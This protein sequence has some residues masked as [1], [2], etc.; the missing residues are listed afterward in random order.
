MVNPTVID[1]KAASSSTSAVHHGDTGCEPDVRLLGG[2]FEFE[3]VDSNLLT[4][5]MPKLIHVK[6]SESLSILVRLIASEVSGNRPGQD[7]VLQKLVE[8]LL[9]EA[10]R[11]SQGIE[12]SAGLLRGLSD[13]RLA[14][15]MRKIHHDPAHPWKVEQLA[16]VCALSRS[17]FFDRFNRVVGIPPMQYLFIWRMALARKMLQNDNHTL[18]EIAHRVGYVSPCTFSMAFSRH[19]GHSPSRFAKIHKAQLTPG[20]ALEQ[21]KELSRQ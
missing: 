3:S 5:L 6:D 15:A 16:E 17:A 18:D 19:T 21:A 9:I 2:Y 20:N 13:E 8:I 4:S 11:S 10:L 1:A 14:E 12:A 7:F